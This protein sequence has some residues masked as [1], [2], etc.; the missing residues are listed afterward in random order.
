MVVVSNRGKRLRAYYRRLLARCEELPPPLAATTFADWDCSCGRQLGMRWFI[1]LA[2]RRPASR[3]ND[4]SVGA[5][6]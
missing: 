6:S 1:E 2:R 5:R 3:A 4:P